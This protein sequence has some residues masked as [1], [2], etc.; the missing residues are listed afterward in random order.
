MVTPTSLSHGPLAGHVAL[1]TG[2]A[3][4]GVG[5]AT[6]YALARDGADVIVNTDRSLDAAEAVAAE[7]RALGRRAIAVVADAGDPAA[8]ATMFR[9]ARLEVGVPDILVVS[10]G[11]RWRP[12]AIDAIPPGEWREV[13]SEEIDSF[14]LA[15]R[16]AL[17]AMRAQ[18]WGRVVAVGGYDAEQTAEESWPLDYALGKAARHWLTRTLARREAEHGVTVN[19]VAPGPITRVPIEAI[20]AHVIEGRSLEGYRRPT[21]VDV[22]EAIAWLCRSPAVNG[23]IIDLPG[24]HPGAV[25]VEG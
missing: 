15:V 9:R 5:R 16:E 20:L 17:P 7:L 24:P 13:L 2:A 6:A 1:V 4:P 14:Y 18:R 21:Q 25:T 11:G 3:G 23:A 10:A 12:R 8:I 19:A 22:A